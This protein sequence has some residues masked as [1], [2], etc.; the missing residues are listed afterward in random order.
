MRRVSDGHESMFPVS[1]R[2]SCILSNTPTN[3]G[4]INVGMQTTIIELPDPFPMMVFIWML[5]HVDYEMSLPFDLVRGIIDQ[6]E[7]LIASYRQQWDILPYLSNYYQQAIIEQGPQGI[8]RLGNATMAAF[9]KGDHDAFE[10]A[11]RL[12]IRELSLHAWQQDDERGNLVPDSIRGT[13][14]DVEIYLVIID[15]ES[16]NNS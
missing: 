14:C 2:T 13:S 15:P 10:M 7:D 11:T 5:E 4:Q 9:W 16:S 1:Q 12:Y 3:I 6:L 8:W